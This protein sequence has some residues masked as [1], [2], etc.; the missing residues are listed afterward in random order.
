MK[1]DQQMMK[2]PEMHDASCASGRVLCVYLCMIA[3]IC[4]F[5]LAQS[6]V[7]G[8]WEACKSQCLGGGEN[9]RL[10][11]QLFS[12]PFLCL[13]KK[14]LLYTHK[15][16]HT[17][18]SDFSYADKRTWAALWQVFLCRQVSSEWSASLSSQRGSQWEM[19]RK[20]HSSSWRLDEC[21]MCSCLT[22]D[23]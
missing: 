10:I 17:H 7:S 1:N 11:P 9:H 20:L 3:C 22:G 8:L 15:D 2:W 13:A 21:S 16:T 12:Q 19:E 6:T 18:A 23:P 4:M 5:I 14:C